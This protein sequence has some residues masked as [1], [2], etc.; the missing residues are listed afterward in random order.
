[1]KKLLSTIETS[2]SGTDAD[3]GLVKLLCTDKVVLTFKLQN[4][5]SKGKV[6]ASATAA[7]GWFHCDI[8]NHWSACDTTEGG[9]L[10]HCCDPGHISRSSGPNPNPDL[11]LT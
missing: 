6:L 9:T 10:R 11:Q 4:P 8:C 1:M 2:K 7:H 3:R 5:T